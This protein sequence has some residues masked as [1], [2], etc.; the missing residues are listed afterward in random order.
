MFCFH[1]DFTLFAAYNI[2]YNHSSNPCLEI[3]CRMSKKNISALLVV[4]ITILLM[5]GCNSV[6][7][8]PE[9]DEPIVGSLENGY[10]IA[11]PESI[12]LSYPVGSMGEDDVLNGPEFEIIR[13]VSHG[14]LIVSGTGP[15]G[16]PIKL[17]NVSEAGTILG[18]TVIDEGGEFL[19]SLENPLVSGHSI[20]I[21]LGD[22]TGT[23]FNESDFIYSDTYYERPLIGIL[24]DIVNVQ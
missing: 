22:I 20:G 5:M 1:K 23:G 4:V 16:V 2:G 9:I 15:T 6:A 19:F 12:E 11:T 7:T 17:V 24:F 14:D 3:G 13:P 8:E 10:P 21:Q 18:E